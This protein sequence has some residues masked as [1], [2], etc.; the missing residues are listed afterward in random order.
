MKFD[1][2]PDR[3]S[4]TYPERLSV[5]ISSD[6]KAKIKFLDEKGKD[7]PEFVRKAIDEALENINFD[8]A[9]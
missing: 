4:I 8:D 1:K 2:I 9:V 6:A 5:A 3:K 7:I